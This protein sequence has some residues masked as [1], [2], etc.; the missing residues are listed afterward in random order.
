MW[1]DGDFLPTL[2]NLNNKTQQVHAGITLLPTAEN[3][4]I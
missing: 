3:Q 4:D 2:Y 1:Q